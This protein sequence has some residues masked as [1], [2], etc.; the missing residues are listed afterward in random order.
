MLR[1]HLED[2]CKIKALLRGAPNKH[3]EGALQRCQTMGGEKEASLKR[4]RMRAKRIAL[5]VLP[6][7]REVNKAVPG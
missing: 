2:L 5:N 7:I 6:G 1:W 4:W 3:E